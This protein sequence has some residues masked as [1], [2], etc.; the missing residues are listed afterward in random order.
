MAPKTRNT[1]KDAAVVAAALK[2]FIKHADSVAYSK[3]SNARICRS[4]IAKHKKPIRSL[5]AAVPNLS[6]SKVILHGALR[7]VHQD[8]KVK[9]HPASV[10]EWVEQNTQ[11][12]KNMMRH[13]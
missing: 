7:Q 5:L 2:P 8:N 1:C 3:E 4:G 10:T 11:K 12:L 13:V 6:V 9:M